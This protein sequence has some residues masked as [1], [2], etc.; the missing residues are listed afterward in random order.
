MMKQKKRTRELTEVTLPRYIPSSRTCDQLRLLK[1][2][3][4]SMLHHDKPGPGAQKQQ[5]KNKERKSAL[6]GVFIHPFQQQAQTLCT[7]I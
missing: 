6:P 4:T 5:I 3:P 2:G 1:I 7:C